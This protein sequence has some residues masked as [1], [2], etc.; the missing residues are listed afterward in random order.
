[1]HAAQEQ[2]AIESGV[3]AG[4]EWLVSA[5][6][7]P[8][9]TMVAAE[10]N[11]VRLGQ[12]FAEIG[13]NPD[14]RSIRY[15]PLHPSC[16]CSVVE[17]LK[18][19][20]G[21]P[22]DPQ[23]SKTLVDP[24]PGADYKPPEGVKGPGPDPAKL[25]PR[26]TPAEHAAAFP[27][28]SITPDQVE[29]YTRFSREKRVL[30]HRT[31]APAKADILANGIDLARANGVYGQGLYTS[32]RPEKSYGPEAVEVAIDARNPLVGPSPELYARWRE[33]TRSE[34][35]LDPERLEPAK[36]IALARKH[37]YDAIITGAHGTDPGEDRWVVICNPDQ[38]RFVVEKPT[39]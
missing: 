1:M 15:P 17:V 6:S 20:Y 25:E 11:R 2:A 7:C 12:A 16:R 21:G 38:C 14:Y 23:W 19:E 29:E 9:C 34:P 4:L 3:V 28:L 5:A 18:P 33:W 32:T 31:Y 35:G 39:P 26:P 13:S 24:R 27:G 36:L 10:A 8:L 30:I 22:E 37:G